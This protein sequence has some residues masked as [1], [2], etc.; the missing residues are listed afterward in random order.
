MSIN[1]IQSGNINDVNPNSGVNQ[2]AKSFS[3]AGE[4]VI[5]GSSDGRKTEM[6]GESSVQQHSLD[7]TQ[8]AIQTENA[9][10]TQEI[11]KT[12]NSKKALSSG[13]FG[14]LK[15]GAGKASGFPG[16]INEA[17]SHIADGKSLENRGIGD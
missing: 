3:F 6:A 15:I 14:G 7:E 2:T 11:S 12:E 4:K 9:E 17:N 8:K 16:G 10:K 5:A 1:Q 13:G